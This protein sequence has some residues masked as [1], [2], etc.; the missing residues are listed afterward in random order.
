L[1]HL[2]I[3]SSRLGQCINRIRRALVTTVAAS[4]HRARHR[5]DPGEGTG[6]GAPQEEGPAASFLHVAALLVEAPTSVGERAVS[7]MERGR[8]GVEDE[9]QRERWV[10]TGVRRGC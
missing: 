2:W 9:K 7:A 6:E 8:G 4:A 3:R 10:V 1:N 5:V